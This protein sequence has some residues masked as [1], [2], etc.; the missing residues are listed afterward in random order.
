MNFI[1][2]PMSALALAWLLASGAATATALADPSTAPS[3]SSDKI[4]IHSTD[5]RIAPP[6]STITDTTGP[7]AKLYRYLGDPVSPP[8]RLD[9]AY[10][11]AGIR[12]VVLLA[13]KNAGIT[14]NILATDESE[15]PCLIAINCE[16][17]AFQ[18]LKAQFK[19]MDKYDYSGS[20]T[21]NSLCIFDIT[22]SRAI[23]AEV[24]TT[25]RRRITLRMS[26]LSSELRPERAPGKLQ[27]SKDGIP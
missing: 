7:N 15:F 26:V 5:A 14:I 9:P 22:P 18:K 20:V 2:K 10:S 12:N 11:P 24:R 27:V 17:A 19:T 25:A 3:P 8:A 13:A 1:N 6:Y 16:D 4:D 21:S 23:P